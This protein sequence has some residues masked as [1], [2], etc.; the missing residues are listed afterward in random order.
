MSFR[1]KFIILLLHYTILCY[2]LQFALIFK[3]LICLLPYSFLYVSQH[4]KTLSSNLLSAECP[5][6]HWCETTILVSWL[7]WMTKYQLNLCNLSFDLWI[8]IELKTAP[9]DYRFPTTNQSRHCFTRYIEFHRYVLRIK[10]LID[11][12]WTSVFFI[13]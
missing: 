9:G 13:W 11:N 1:W 4:Y 8:Q 12:S 7:F 10:L 2:L 3:S 5:K 6:S